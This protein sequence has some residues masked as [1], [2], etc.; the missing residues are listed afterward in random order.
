MKALKALDRLYGID[1]ADYQLIKAI[2]IDAYQVAW[3]AYGRAQFPNGVN[4]SGFEKWLKEQQPLAEEA[5]INKPADNIDTK[6]TLSKTGRKFPENFQEEPKANKKRIKYSPEIFEE[7]KNLAQR[8]LSNN[9]IFTEIGVSTATFYK[10]KNKHPELAEV[11]NAKDRYNQN[12]RGQ[13]PR[14]PEIQ[15]KH[16]E[17]AIRGHQKRKAEKPLNINKEALEEITGMSAK[18]YEAKRQK[19]GRTGY[20][21][22]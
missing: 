10:W 2:L 18:K 20:Y 1:K 21:D 3:C 6:V 12:G 8:G 5:P 4:E 22:D 14:T 16:R 17:A 19:Y 13:H 7:I 11:L 9:E 15:Q